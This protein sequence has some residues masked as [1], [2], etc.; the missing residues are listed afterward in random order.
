MSLR[1]S[2][3]I[4]CMLAVMCLTL[5]AGAQSPADPDIPGHTILRFYQTWF[6]GADGARC[7][8]YPSC[9]G[10]A[11]R[12]FK[13]HGPVMGWI[14]TCDRLL[15]CGR[16]ETRLAPEIRIHGQTRVFDPV[17]AN[18]FWWFTPRL[19]PEKQ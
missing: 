15:R 14:M 18:D 10:Y 6:S 2:W 19:D 7:P 17:D 4:L 12:A 13:K 8:M 16:S 1:N 11:D 3:M 5:P 9:S